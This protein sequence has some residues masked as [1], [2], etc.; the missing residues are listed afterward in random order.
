MDSFSIDTPKRKWIF[1][2]DSN[3]NRELWIN[4]LRQ[5]CNYYILTQNE[6]YIKLPK[7]K[8]YKKQLNSQLKRDYFAFQVTLTSSQLILKLKTPIKT[9]SKL[10]DKDNT[11]LSMS[12]SY[13][14]TN[15][16]GGESVSKSPPIIISPSHSRTSSMQSQ[17]QSQS[18]DNS[19]SHSNSN[20]YSHSRSQ[21][22]RFL[23][24][25]KDKTDDPITQNGSTSGNKG[26]TVI[27]ENKSESKCE[28][29]P[30]II[31]NGSKTKSKSKGKL[32]GKS[33]QD[34]D[35]D[36][37]KGDHD[38]IRWNLHEI[39]IIKCLKGNV[40][41][42]NG[43]GGKSSSNHKSDGYC[44]QILLILGRSEKF[45]PYVKIYL[46]DGKVYSKWKK[47]FRQY[48]FNAQYKE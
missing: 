17:S 25:N 21:S 20:S 24:W 46:G 4:Y 42:K 12:N 47:M 14:W 34:K 11:E 32:N 40:G 48:C 9:L 38:D 33:K 23:K 22:K 16:T 29:L 13:N 30:N 6:M 10:H 44:W 2:T 43:K 39:G 19:Y 15:T 45:S 5:S 1:A 37:N 8:K 36:K 41:G 27:D 35:K 7:D 3:D 26:P 31:S 18:H 28:T